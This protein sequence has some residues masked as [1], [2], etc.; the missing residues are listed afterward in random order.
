VT[1]PATPP[2]KPASVT[3]PSGNPP[4][5]KSPAGKPPPGK[6][7][8][9]AY[10]LGRRGLLKAI[11]VTSALALLGK[12]LSAT[13]EDV[14]SNVLATWLGYGA[15]VLITV[16]G[17]VAKE[18][19]DARRVEESAA[20]EPLST[21]LPEFP[22]SKGRDAVVAQVV[23]LAG[24]HGN[25]L[26]HG[27]AGIGTST[28]AARAARRL[29]PDPDADRRTYVD[30]RGQSPGRAE[31][32]ARVRTRV[33]AALGLPPAA[34]RDAVG[35][36]AEVA[37]RLAA[38]NRLLLLDNVAGADQI[39]WLTTLPGAH[40]L[41]AGTAN[42]ADLPGFADVPVGPL[43]PA[44][45][46]EVLYDTVPPQHRPHIVRQVARLSAEQRQLAN[47]Y[48]GNP[49]VALRM[50][51]WLASAPN[52]SIA[53]LLDYLG[54]GGAGG[55]PDAG[56]TVRHLLHERINEGLSR[57]G[58]RLVRLLAAAPVSELSV[59]AI[60]TYAGWR[61]GRIR[62]AL[63]ELEPRSLVLRVRPARYRIPEAVRAAGAAGTGTGRAAQARLLRYYARTAAQHIGALT[64]PATADQRYAAQNWFKLEDTALLVLLQQD[65]PRGRGADLWTIGDV[66]DVWFGRDGRPE[67][68]YET[69][70]ALAAAARARGATVVEE[71]ALLR[72]V[73][74][75]ELLG[76]DPDEHMRRARELRGRSRSGPRHS[77][78]HE[79]EGRRLIAAGD[80]VAAANEFRSARRHRPRRDR[81]GRVIDLTNLGT[82]LLEQGDPDGARQQADEALVI[83]Q[84][85][86]DVAGQA[87]A[88]EL[89]G[90]VAARRSAY[91]VAKAELER[92]RPLY[93]EL[94][95]TLGQARCLT[96]LATVRL[97]ALPAGS[98]QSEA[99]APE[100]A[101]VDELLR[102][103]LVLREA[104]QRSPDPDGTDPD[105]TG[106]D[107]TGSDGDP[108]APP[109]GPGLR[110][111]IAL[112]RSVLAQVAA[113][114][115]DADAV[116][117][118]RRAGLVAL[119][120]PE[121]PGTEPPA[122]AE[123]RRRLAEPAA[124][125]G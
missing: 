15:P 26:I 50:G 18:L 112:T 81:I 115:G 28:V 10:R 91:H 96:H 120:E 39:G 92:A 79:H 100:L 33:L 35:A 99:V 58:R 123:L 97:A 52:V 19:Y 14:L 113:V 87:H 24:T 111:G 45:A 48:L 8:A 108:D 119:G 68:R 22:A 101:E 55:E 56:S 51:G 64:G 5:G 77:R 34:A 90:L 11:T 21:P 17:F 80:A 7:A 83:A 67:D 73:A 63:A 23:E 13:L 36:A 84:R 74:V 59:A 125:L 116:T 16:V 69:A 122:T 29:V 12:L 89:L 124:R 86:G 105:G 2:V 118:H 4:P 71:T 114:R 37:R 38:E 54:P 30:L 88:R 27:P 44:A 76:R 109:Y 61:A 95:D 43:P 75:D 70:T 72:L 25:V 121:P 106:S 66:L 107:G 65:E 47:W 40:V 32:A 110:F 20:P 46:V 42:P 102:E 49:S 103:S 85:A 93:A 1:E 82:A 53:S 41:A 9:P 104:S 98:R 60:A 6:A 31:G 78:L 117:R 62:A 57:D 94:N 3:P